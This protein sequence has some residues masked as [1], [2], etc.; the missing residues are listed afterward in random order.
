[1][2]RF[3]PLS[4][5]SFL[6]SKWEPT[7]LLQPP[8]NDSL[9]FPSTVA[10][11]PSSPSPSPSDGMRCCRSGW[12]GLCLFCCS[13]CFIN[14]SNLRCCRSDWPGPCL[15]CC[16]QP[17]CVVSQRVD[18]GF[19]NFPIW[20]PLPPPPPPPHIRFISISVSLLRHEPQRWLRASWTLLF[21]PYWKWYQRILK[22]GEGNISLFWLL[23]KE[24]L[25]F[26]SLTP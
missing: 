24:L 21:R 16:Y 26:Q 14:F 3:W 7:S 8:W 25:K 20:L 19:K 10:A 4:P 11:F 9:R 23:L 22:L 17:S 18:L 6:N 2:L 5:P 13:I 15:F 12:L 1:M